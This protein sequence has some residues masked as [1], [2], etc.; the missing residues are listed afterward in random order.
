MRWF[1]AGVEP[2]GVIAVG[3]VPTGVIAIGQGATGIIAV[4]QLA[5]GVVAAGQVSIGVLA[6]GQAAIGAAWAG[7]MLAL[8]G[9]YGITLLGYG[10]L[11]YWIPWRRRLPEMPDFGN[12]LVMAARLLFFLV[13]IAA[14]VLVVLIPVFD[15]VVGSDAIFGMASELLG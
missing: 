7:G 5:R 13:L 6:F 10:P 14:V 1:A 9:T 15:A 3:Q 11:G 4:G 8:G 2:V 12:P